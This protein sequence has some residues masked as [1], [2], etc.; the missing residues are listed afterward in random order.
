[1]DRAIFMRRRAVVFR[2]LTLALLVLSILLTFL[3]GFFLRYGPAGF[4]RN[5]VTAAILGLNQ[6]TLLNPYEDTDY[7]LRIRLS[8][9]GAARLI[10]SLLKDKDLLS[11]L[12]VEITDEDFLVMSSRVHTDG[13]VSILGES[14]QAL[15]NSFGHLPDYVYIHIV[16]SLNYAEKKSSLEELRLGKL[17][18]P[19]IFYAAVG[20]SIDKGLED[21][22]SNAL[23]LD[24]ENIAVEDGKLLIEAKFTD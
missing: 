19:S 22:F 13:I 9:K 6:Q 2:G 1:M 7:D 15:E 16:L 3:L 4:F 24:L 8:P 14:R 20:A 11:D 5:P 17:K 12:Q 23:G 21:F 18:I 10:D